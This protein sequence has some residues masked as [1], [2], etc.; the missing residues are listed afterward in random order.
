MSPLPF[1]T[2]DPGDRRTRI[3]DQWIARTPEFPGSSPAGY[4]IL[5]V[6]NGVQ[7]GARLQAEAAV[8]AR[9]AQNVHLRRRASGVRHLDDHQVAIVLRPERPILRI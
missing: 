4:T 6:G 3:S 8:V 2:K 5:R 9:R 7:R 1:T